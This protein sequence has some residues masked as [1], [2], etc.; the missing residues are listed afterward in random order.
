MQDP[1]LQSMLTDLEQELAAVDG[2]L[3]AS[4]LDEEAA[5]VWRCVNARLVDSDA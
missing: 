1:A 3:A 4:P 2:I 5:V